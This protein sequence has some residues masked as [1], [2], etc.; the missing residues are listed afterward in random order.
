MVFCRI[1]TETTIY[2]SFYRVT[3]IELT[4][5]EFAM[6]NKVLA[7]FLRVCNLNAAT[8]PLNNTVI[9]RLTAGLSLKR[10]HIQNDLDGA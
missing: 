4:P 2:R 10:C 8:C 5:N 3:N 6:V 9:S 1:G 7:L